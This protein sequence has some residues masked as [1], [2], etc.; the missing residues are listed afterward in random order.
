LEIRAITRRS[1]A[2]I[3]WRLAVGNQVLSYLQRSAIG[4]EN[5]KSAVAI[6]ISR[7][8]G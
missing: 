5:R 1:A 8:I 2:V 3:G 7:G 6:R 4:I